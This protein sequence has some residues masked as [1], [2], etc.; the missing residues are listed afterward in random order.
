MRPCPWPGC[1]VL[2]FRTVACPRHLGLLEP[3]QRAIVGWYWDL[4]DAGK[5]TRDKRED[6]VRKVC[7]TQ[8]ARLKN[9]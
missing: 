5:V 6:L 3:V 7:Q 4:F 2:C 9:G 1:P 8:A